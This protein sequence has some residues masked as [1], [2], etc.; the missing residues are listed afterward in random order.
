MSFSKILQT[1]EIPAPVVGIFYQA[2][3]AAVLLYG[4][5]LRRLPPSAVK[6]LEGFH[7]VASCRLTGMMAKKRGDTCV[8][9]K[10]PEVMAVARLKTMKEYIT[11]RWQRAAALV[12]RQPILSACRE[13]E[14]MSG[15]APRQYWQDQGID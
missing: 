14:R 2:V 8:Y 4:S 13:A 6:L 7:T 11:I 15:T 3:I 10:T 5:E 1:E 9:P 12:V